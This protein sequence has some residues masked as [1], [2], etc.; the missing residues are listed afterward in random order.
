MKLLS[1]FLLFT[2]Y[3]C[4]NYEVNSCYRT[5]GCDQAVE[6]CMGQ[7]LFF[8]NN[9]DFPWLACLA[10][11]NSCEN[12]CKKCKNEKKDFGQNPSCLT[13]QYKF[14]FGKKPPEN[15]FPKK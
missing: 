2:L 5:N 8:T 3:S 13:N 10:F 12:F 7:H 14:L 9:T 15:P 4:Y 11:K 6:T 1:L